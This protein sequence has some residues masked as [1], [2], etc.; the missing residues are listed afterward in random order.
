MNT[1][2]YRRARE[3][4]RKIWK[5]FTYNSYLQTV[6]VLSCDVSPSYHP[7]AQHPGAPKVHNTRHQA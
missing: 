4:Q 5:L 7:G 1:Y 6:Y 3:S 2:M